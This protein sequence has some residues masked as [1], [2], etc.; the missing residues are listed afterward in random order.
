M[1]PVR[2]DPVSGLVPIFSLRRDIDR[3]FGDLFREMGTGVGDVETVK[4]LLGGA[5]DAGLNLID[6]AECYANSEELIG[7]TVSARRKDYWLLTKV[8]HPKGFGTEDWSATGIAKSI[9]R[10][11]KRLRTDHVDVL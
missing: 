7:A 6:T 1:L 8:G 3:L 5:L 11:L 9:E 2:Y 10:S 4:R